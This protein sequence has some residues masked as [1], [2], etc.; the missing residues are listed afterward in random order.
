MPGQA[1]AFQ[2]ERD[3][4][5]G[6]SAIGWRALATP[7][8]QFSHFDLQALGW[9]AV[10]PTL[11]EG[12]PGVALYGGWVLRR[13]KGRGNSS[14]Y[15][16]L[17]ER[18]GGIEIGQGLQLQLHL[19]ALQMRSGIAAGVVLVSPGD[20]ERGRLDLVG[21]VANTAAGLLKLVPAGGIAALVGDCR[22]LRAEVVLPISPQTRLGLERYLATRKELNEMAWARKMRQELDDSCYQFCQAAKYWLDAMERAQFAVKR[23][24]NISDDA[25][26]Q[27]LKRL[28]SG[29]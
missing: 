15:L 21:D 20:M 5:G 17:H 14:Y 23:G 28:V 9:H 6:F 27:K 22:R 19:P 12:M 3:P 18:A 11:R 25:T 26:I 24:L 1:R 13:R 8:E 2:P 10:A 4:F 29:A 16:A 7:L